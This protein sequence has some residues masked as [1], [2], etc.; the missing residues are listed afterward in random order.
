MFVFWSALSF[1]LGF[2]CGVIGHEADCRRRASDDKVSDCEPDVHQERKVVLRN[3]GVLLLM[4]DCPTI[5]CGRQR[6]DHQLLCPHCW[7]AVRAETKQLFWRAFREKPHGTDHLRYAEAARSEA[8][9][10]VDRTA[11]EKI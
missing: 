8:Q 9:E 7:K 10:A 1:C 11:R 3:M 6:D 2:A 5:G 4:T